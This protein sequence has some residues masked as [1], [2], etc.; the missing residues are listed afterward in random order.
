MRAIE[1]LSRTARATRGRRQP[2]LF[3][4]VEPDLVSSVEHYLL[5]PPFDGTIYEHKVPSE[6]WQGNSVCVRLV[7]IWYHYG[8]FE[9][10]LRSN[11]TALYAANDGISY[12][13]NNDSARCDFARGAKRSLISA[14]FP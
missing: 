6:Q 11:S 4:M 5:A 8:A 7:H 9:L 10:F 13:F 12:T 2:V 14:G 3:P 1:N